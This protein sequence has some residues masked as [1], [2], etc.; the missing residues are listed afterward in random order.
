[1]LD[2]RVYYNRI[3]ICHQGT[4]VRHHEA[5]FSNQ[6]MIVADFDCFA[7]ALKSLYAEHRR[8][9]GGLLKQWFAPAPAVHLDVR[10]ELA[11]GLA[12]LEQKALC[13]A[14]LVMGA[15]RVDVHY[16]GQ[17]VKPWQPH[18]R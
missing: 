4:E 5:P 7:H 15:R 17:L 1:M 9:P 10:V 13:D 12:P 16:R 14:A 8:Q 6:R 11:D 3:T 18:R 2:I